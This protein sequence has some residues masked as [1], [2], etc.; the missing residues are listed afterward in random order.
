MY[1][2]THV[3]QQVSRLWS[4]VS[5]FTREVNNELIRARISCFIKQ[6]DQLKKLN[7]NQS[8][9]FRKNDLNASYYRVYDVL[10]N[11]NSQ[12]VVL[13]SN[14]PRSRGC[15]VSPVHIKKLFSSLTRAIEL[16]KKKTSW[17]SNYFIP[18]SLYLERRLADF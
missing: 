1:I 14:V 18:V 15:F 17:A 12:G 11:F 4:R 5:D 3:K 8:T 6:H 7:L 2:V 9:L 13:L 10:L 16:R